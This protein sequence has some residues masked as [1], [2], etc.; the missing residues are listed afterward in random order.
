MTDTLVVHS[1]PLAHARWVLQT[2]M[3]AVTSVLFNRPNAMFRLLAGV[4]LTLLASSFILL[5]ATGRR[6]ALALVAAK[7]AQ[8]AHQAAHDPLTGLPNRTLVL[9]RAT[10]LIARHTRDPELTAALF[11]DIDG[12]KEV[13]DTMGHAAGDGLLR[14]VAERLQATVRGQDTVGRMGGD[15]FVVLFE[16]D[17]DEQIEALADRLNRVLREPTLLTPGAAPVQVTASIGIAYG[18]YATPD[19]LLSDA[20]MALYQAKEAGKDRHVLF[21]ASTELTPEIVARNI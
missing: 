15:E 9:D 2:F 21:S 3:P 17:P 7:T 19:E 14:T 6:R 20:D 10:Q 12:F 13:N 16:A 18:R 4:L 5:L 1:V 8:L 11:I